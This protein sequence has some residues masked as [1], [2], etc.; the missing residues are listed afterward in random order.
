[1][2]P[3]EVICPT[4]YI[5][6]INQQPSEAILVLASVIVATGVAVSIA[7]E[8]CYALFAYSCYLEHPIVSE[9]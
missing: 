4:A 2:F 3:F 6:E 9:L 1:M 7:S 8:I 5:E